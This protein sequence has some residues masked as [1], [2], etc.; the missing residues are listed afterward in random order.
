MSNRYVHSTVKKVAALVGKALKYLKRSTSS[1]C[2]LPKFQL[3]ESKLCSCQWR[4]C[5]CRLLR[6]LHASILR[7]WSAFRSPAFAFWLHQLDNWKATTWRQ[8]HLKIVIISNVKNKKLWFTSCSQQLPTSQRF[9][10]A[11]NTHAARKIFVGCKINSNAGGV[12]KMSCQLT[13]ASN[14]NC[15]LLIAILFSSFFDIQNKA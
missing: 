14:M 10:W 15:I 1:W 3:T 6:M 7:S 9:H 12:A 2:Q 4:S 11:V 13:S 5:V 8:R